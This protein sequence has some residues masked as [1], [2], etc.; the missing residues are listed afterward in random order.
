LAKNI[1]RARQFQ[2]A[3]WNAAGWEW[4]EATFDYRWIHKP[5][6]ADWDDRKRRGMVPVSFCAYCGEDDLAGGSQWVNMHSL[7]KVPVNLC[8]SCY[9]QMAERLGFNQTSVQLPLRV[10]FIERF[11]AGGCCLIVA[12]LMLCILALI[13]AGYLLR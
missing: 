3:L 9:A 6:G 11:G 13:V 7:L 4:T 8:S 2:K 1:E 5:L 10:R 12:L